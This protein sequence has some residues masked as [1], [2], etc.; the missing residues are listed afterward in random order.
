V[1]DFVPAG[2]LSRFVVAL[3]T[4]ELDLSAILA[5]Y[6]GEKGQPPAF[7]PAQG[8]ANAVDLPLSGGGMESTPVDR[9]IC[10][11]LRSPE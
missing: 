1:H 2:H 11:A 9:V 4:E 10:D 7:A 3:V 8:R 6:Q 5:S